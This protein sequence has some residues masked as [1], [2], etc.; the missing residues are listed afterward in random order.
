MVSPCSACLVFKKPLAMY[1]WKLIYDVP[2]PLHDDNECEH[3]ISTTIFTWQSRVQTWA[4]LSCDTHESYNHNDTH[5]A[6]HKNKYN[7]HCT[8]TSNNEYPEMWTG[9]GC[10]ERCTCRVQTL[11][12]NLSNDLSCL[13]V[14]SN[15]SGRA[16]CVCVC[17]KIIA[18]RREE[19]DGNSPTCCIRKF[20]QIKSLFLYFVLVFFSSSG[21]PI[22]ATTTTTTTNR[23]HSHRAIATAAVAK[24][25]WL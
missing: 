18:Q 24:V 1:I 16:D 21:Y 12:L 23:H 19:D 7:V 6:L 11:H 20:N 8:W 25:P 14:W 17:A 15:K 13:L 10:S 4:W 2:P 3:N 5:R 22:T 9:C